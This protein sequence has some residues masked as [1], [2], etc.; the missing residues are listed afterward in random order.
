MQ[1]PAPTN[2]TRSL[3]AEGEGRRTPLAPFSP[4][5]GRG[6]GVRGVEGE[7]LEERRGRGGGEGRRTP[8]APFSH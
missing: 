5:G 8:L 3:R 4:E 1:F 7:G 2:L 6:W